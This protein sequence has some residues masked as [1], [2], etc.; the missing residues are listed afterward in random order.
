MTLHAQLRR[1]TTRR[2][3]TSGIN[4]LDRVRHR[5]QRRRTAEEEAARR[6]SK[7]SATTQ[8][9]QRDDAA[10]P[11]AGAE[12]DGDEARQQARGDIPDGSPL[13][14]SLRSSRGQIGPAESHERGEGEKC[15]VLGAKAHV[16]P[17]VAVEM[18][19]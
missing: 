12:F 16:R 15:L 11:S 9:R 13:R 8:Q 1:E 7:G 17:K 14:G 6:R 2:Y 4:E 3:G 10:I 5:R 19:H 18:Q